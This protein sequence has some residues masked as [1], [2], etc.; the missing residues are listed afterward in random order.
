MF[1]DFKYRSTPSRG[2]Q[3]VFFE[4]TQAAVF[5]VLK[6]KLDPPV[7][8]SCAE[9]IKQIV[10]VLLRSFNEL[11]QIC[12]TLVQTPWLLLDQASCF[13]EPRLE[14]ETVSREVPR[15]HQVRIDIIKKLL[16]S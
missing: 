13:S 14:K 8:D 15:R 5:N 2:V 4:R 12:G 16:H 7:V 11:P 6:K 10:N 3:E 1:L 9:I